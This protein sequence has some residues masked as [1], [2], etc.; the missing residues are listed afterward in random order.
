M[1]LVE[2]MVASGVGS[3]CLMA[4]VSIWMFSARGFVALWN[5]AELE[6]QSRYALDRMTQEIRQANGLASYSAT[7]LNFTDHDGQT[8]SYAYQPDSKRL[9]R[10]KGNEFKVLL[11]QCDYLK[12]SIY[13]RNPIGGTFDQVPATTATECK[14]LQLH[15]VCSRQIL[16]TLLNTE[17]VQSAKIVIRK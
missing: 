6:S 15:W 8:L 10:I 4:I 2:V 1:T 3:L 13:Q 5:Y 7:Q 12:F 16:G 9:V 11:Q 17:S 14:M